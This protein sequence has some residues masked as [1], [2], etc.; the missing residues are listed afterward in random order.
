MRNVYL[1]SLSESINRLGGRNHWALVGWFTLTCFVL[2]GIV[3][4]VTKA[5]VR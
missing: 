4:M 5:V 2:I 3:D 1:R